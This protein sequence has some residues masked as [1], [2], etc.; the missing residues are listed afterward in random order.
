MGQL[1]IART[2]QPVFVCAGRRHG[3]T[4]NTMIRLVEFACRVF[5]EAK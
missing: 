4:A 5:A 2:S 1:K 3:F